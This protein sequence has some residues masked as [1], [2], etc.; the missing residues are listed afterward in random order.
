MSVQAKANGLQL[1]PVPDELSTLNALEPR[2]I[3]LRVPRGGYRGVLGV[4][5]HPPPPPAKITY[6]LL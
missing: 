1:D 2:L 3:S 4:L 6:R 5:K